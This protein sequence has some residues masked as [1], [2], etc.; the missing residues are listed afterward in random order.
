MSSHSTKGIADHLKLGDYNAACSM[1]GRKRTAST[2]VKKW[3]GMYR[4]PD[5]NE[6]RH[7]QE[8]V[9]AV[10]DMQTPPWTQ[11]P[12][13]GFSFSSISITDDGDTDVEVPINMPTPAGG[14][15]PVVVTI[16]EGVAVEELTFMLG[17]GAASNVTLNI[18][19][20]LV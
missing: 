19:G 1:C 6:P 14:S 3:Q 4:C 12:V 11:P 17:A 7:P 16:P 10:P 8:F 13:D 15:P 9:R 2:L 20:S 18:F 5:H